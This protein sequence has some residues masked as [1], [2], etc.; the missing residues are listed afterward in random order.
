[1]SAAAR[2]QVASARLRVATY[3]FGKVMF[4]LTVPFCGHLYSC[5][6]C[7]SNFTAVFPAAT[8]P[9]ENIARLGAGVRVICPTCTSRTAAL[10]PHPRLF[11][12]WKRLTEL[13][14]NYGDR[15]PEV[16]HFWGEHRNS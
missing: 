8:H 7:E 3:P 4:L 5:F 16:L 1:M 14:I 15:P 9:G 10:R 11:G 13:R 12:Q 2:K 6:R